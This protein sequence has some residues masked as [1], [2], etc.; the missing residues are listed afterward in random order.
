MRVCLTPLYNEWPPRRWG[1][2][3]LNGYGAEAFHQVK[4]KSKNKET[5]LSARGISEAHS[6]KEA[7]CSNMKLQNKKFG[8][9]L[10]N[11]FKSAMKMFELLK[12]C[13]LNHNNN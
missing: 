3:A 11:K 8:S 12:V 10:R 7:G 4:G 1:V 5:Y 2:W 9:S 13:F 6:D